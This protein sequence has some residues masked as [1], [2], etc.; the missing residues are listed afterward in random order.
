MFTL[1]LRWS[2]SRVLDGFTKGPF[3][4]SHFL[5][6]EGDGALVAEQ[7]VALESISK[8]PRGER[9]DEAIARDRQDPPHEGDT[10]QGKETLVRSNK[11]VPPPK[12]PR[13][14][15]GKKSWQ[16]AL[17]LGANIPMD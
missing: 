14:V 4:T 5:V 7:G 17:A 1:R 9:M 8:N 11:K 10:N 3:S 6:D 12:K 16:Y 15:R 13:I 2:D